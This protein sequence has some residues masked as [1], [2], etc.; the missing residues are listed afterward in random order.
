LGL[1]HAEARFSR[2]GTAS[3]GGRENWETSETY[4]RSFRLT[5]TW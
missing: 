3:R 4:L 1:P 5:C 2:Y